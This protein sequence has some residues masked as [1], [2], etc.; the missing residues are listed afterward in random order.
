MN[1]N[2]QE[3][4]TL[5]SA[6]GGALKANIDGLNLTA[7]GKPIS[8]SATAV[9]TFPSATTRAVAWDGSWQRTNEL[10]QVVAHTSD[11]RISVDL[12]AG[13]RT[14]DGTAQ[15]YVDAREV[16]TTITGYQLCH[17]VSGQEGCP[18]GA[19]NH[20]GVTSGKTVQIQFDGTAEAEVTGPRGDMFQVPLVCT[21]L[22][23]GG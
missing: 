18:S 14:I 12:A 16:N 9:I 4:V 13:C 23:A 1:I 21:P 6:T 15:T 2:G 17:D 10:G 8:H 3:T 5:G 7:N 22:A 19:V 20:V 11:V